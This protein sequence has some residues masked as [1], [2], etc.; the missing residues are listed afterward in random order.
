MMIVGKGQHKLQEVCLEIT[1]ICPMECVHCSG[2]CNLAS[3]YVL[4]LLEVKRI[5]DEFAGMNGRILEISGGEPLMHPNLFEIVAHAKMNQLETVLYTSGVSLDSDGRMISIGTDLAEKLRWLGLDKVVFN[6]QGA[7]LET[8]ERITRKKGSF[9]RVV[10]SIEIMKSAGC[11]VG[12]H[13]VPMKPNYSKLRDVIHLCHDLGVDEIGLLQFVPQGRGL[14]N[15]QSL[16]LSRK[17]FKEFTQDVT[18]LTYIHKNPHIRVGRPADFRRLLD[19]SITKQ[20]CNA[21]VS[22]CLITPDGNVVPCPAFKQHQ[23]SVAGNVK[24]ESLANI[25][26]NS[27][28]W[29]EFRGFDYTQMNEPCKG[30]EHLYWCQGGCRAQRV[31]EY[32]DMYKGPDPHCFAHSLRQRLLITQTC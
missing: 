19:S 10:K 5:I 28:V 23:N 25:W 14:V 16:E 20:V 12:V 2:S 9:K 30:C 15:R 17:E 22:R 27:H 32:G 8:H 3:E 31:L 18:E 7:T 13:F 21:G 1:S 29:K 11:W 6:L 26:F 4:S 24:S